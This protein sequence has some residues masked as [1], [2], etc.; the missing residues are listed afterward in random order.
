MN[1]FVCKKNRNYTRITIDCDDNCISG[2][3]DYVVDI[4]LKTSSNRNIYILCCGNTYRIEQG[5]IIQQAQVNSF[6]T[7][8]L[9]VKNE[10]LLICK[11]LI[12][13]RTLNH[14]YLFSDDY[15]FDAFINNKLCDDRFFKKEPKLHIIVAL[16]DCER[17]ELFIKDS[18]LAEQIVQ[19]L[20]NHD[21]ESK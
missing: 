21:C 6:P 3:I 5:V 8:K 19:F 9:W 13:E 10:W 18:Y 11:N 1:S 15:P 12:F 14:I 17:P 16:E 20:I 7:L 2:F 4:I